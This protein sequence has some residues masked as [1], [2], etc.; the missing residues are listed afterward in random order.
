[1]YKTP[2]LLLYDPTQPI[3]PDDPAIQEFYYQTRGKGTNPTFQSNKR[4]RIV[5]V[6]PHQLY[7]EVLEWK[8][9]Q[10]QVSSI[11]QMTSYSR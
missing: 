4:L 5:L 3:D 7:E 6:I 1:M 8:E 9:H 11:P 2:K 10:L